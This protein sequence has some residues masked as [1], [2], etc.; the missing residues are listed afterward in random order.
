MD[1]AIESLASQ[2][3]ELLPDRVLSSDRSRQSSGGPTSGKRTANRYFELYGDD[4]ADES[5]WLHLQNLILR[6][7]DMPIYDRLI[8]G[9][10]DIA[11]L[12][13]GCSDG[14]VLND[15]L[16]F[17]GEVTSLL[18]VDAN[19]AMLAKAHD[20]FGSDER[21]TFLE[22]DCEAKDFRRVLEGYLSEKGLTGFDFVNISMVILHLKRPYVL[23]RSLQRVLNPGACIFIRDID[24]GLNIAHPDDD[25]AFARL[26]DLCA[27]LPTTGCRTSGRQIFSMLKR[28]GYEDIVLDRSGLST[29]GMS[30]E[31]RYALFMT[32]FDWLGGDL[33]LRSREEPDNEEYRQDW[34]WFEDNVY[35]LEEQFQDS[36]F[37]Y[38]EGFMAFTAR[39]AKRGW[40][41][42]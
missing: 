37:F 9:R 23:L 26:N 41:N 7:F 25:G 15:R 33:E 21:Y 5:R 31:Q 29:V 2:I 6:D 12:D 40:A 38:Q 27:S 13:I 20:R 11:V 39:T 10:S 30:H 3:C 4:A 18:G 28:A 17:R 32:C 24:D 19:A 36:T 35:D 8:E 42:R 14:E 16:G 1:K 22:A 34:E